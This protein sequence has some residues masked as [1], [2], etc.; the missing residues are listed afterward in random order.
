M[1]WYQSS[2]TAKNHLGNLRRERQRLLISL[3][4]MT[5]L[6]PSAYQC[7]LSV[8]FGRLDFPSKH[9]DCRVGGAIN[10]ADTQTDRQTYASD[11]LSFKELCQ[12][13]RKN[14]SGYFFLNTMYD[15]D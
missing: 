7:F 1:W 10:R 11:L 12:R 5:G 15:N 14:E 6:A 8:K 13:Q 4:L 3:S 2:K 9:S